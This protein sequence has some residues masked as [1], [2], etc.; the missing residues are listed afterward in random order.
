MF[1]LE[2]VSTRHPLLHLEI[3]KHEKR[4]RFKPSE[5][6]VPNRKPTVT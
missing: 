4:K 3:E 1:A 6:T 2:I 5:P